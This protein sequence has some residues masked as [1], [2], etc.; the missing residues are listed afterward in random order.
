MDA[1]KSPKLVAKAKRLYWINGLSFESVARTNLGNPKSAMTIRRWIG[2]GERN[3]HGWNSSKRQDASLVR[4]AKQLRLVRGLSF[5]KVA[6]ILHTSPA[7]VAF[8][9]GRPFSSRIRKGTASRKCAE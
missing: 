1:K 5:R 3:R 8:L 9:V 7:T 2:P 4:R 6:R